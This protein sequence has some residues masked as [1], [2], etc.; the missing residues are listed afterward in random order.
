MLQLLGGLAAEL[1]N[2]FMCASRTQV[3][4]IITFFVAFH[5]LSAIDKIYLEA[6]A[7]MDLL[8][9]IHDPLYFKRSHKTVKNDRTS[10]K[11]VY[12]VWLVLNFF[13][14]SVYYYYLP[15]IV[16]FVPYFFAAPYEAH[17]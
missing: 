7:D 2:L 16:N 5:A 12:L 15:F 8:V 1:M 14:N 9:T 17:H 13:Y 11:L 10:F 4:V 6:V 3:D